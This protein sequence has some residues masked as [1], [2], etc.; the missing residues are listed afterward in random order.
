MVEALEAYLEDLE[1]EAQGVRE[2]L[3]DLNADEE[4]P[5]PPPKPPRKRASAKAK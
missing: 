1:N 2:F 3:A 5:E 4:A